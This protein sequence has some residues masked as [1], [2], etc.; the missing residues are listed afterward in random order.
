MGLAFAHTICF[1]LWSSRYNKNN[2]ALVP[3][4]GRKPGLR[5]RNTINRQ[6]SCY[7]RAIHCENL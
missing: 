2:E 4:C 5:N 6:F 7:W 1:V 3:Q